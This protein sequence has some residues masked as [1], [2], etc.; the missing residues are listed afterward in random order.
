MNVADII[1]DFFA[2][3]KVKSLFFV[4][5]GGAMFLNDAISRQKKIIPYPNH[6]EQASTI[7]AE[8]Y[9]RVDENI[10]LAVV[11]TGPGGT[12][13]I[14]GIAGAWLESVPLFIITG[15]VKRSD[16]KKNSGVRQ[17]G[18][19]ELDIVKIVE[20][21]TKYSKTITNPNSILY[22]LE[23]AFNI[24]TTGR[25]GPVLL[26]IPLD[27]QASIVKKVD[28]ESFKNIKKIR[29][30]V[31][32]FKNIK[33]IING[34]SKPLILIGHGVRLSGG[35]GLIIKFIKKYKIPFVTT[36]NAMDIFPYDDKLNVGRPG[37]VALRAPNFAIQNCD[38]IIAIGA[39]LDNIVTAYNPA[40][41]AKNAKKIIVDI[42]KFELKKFKHKVDYKIN[43]SAN[44]FLTEFI[45]NIGVDF[46]N[47]SNDWK[48]QCIDWKQRYSINDGKAFKK[49]KEISHLYCV[50]ILSNILPENCLIVTGSSGLAIES[51]YTAFRN[52]KNQRIFLTSALGSMGYGIPALYGS[53]SSDK[54]KKIFCIESDGSFMMNMQ[55]MASLSNI[56]KDLKIIILNNK[57]YSSIRNTQRNYFNSRFLAVD[58][59]SNLNIPEFS[60][61]ADCFNFKHFKIDNPL[62][63][64]TQ[65]KKIIN[66]KGNIICE[67]I[68][69]QDD[70][71][72]PKSSAIPLPNG[73]IISMP[74]E[75]MSPLL[76]LDK[77]KLEMNNKIDPI[78]IKVRDKK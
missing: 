74:I 9:S 42:D 10:G 49:D 38:L 61:I 28:L 53:A 69:K 19:Q 7:S 21:I 5:G 78:S 58:K 64:D 71:L 77:L 52:K 3:K 55:E 40:N 12:N 11:T 56:Q 33:K 60:K 65:L 54:F 23:K 67:I 13:A 36:W 63:I 4:P 48:K 35:T 22:E 62:T 2:K 73:K 59:G 32:D 39:R 76:P 45:K 8:A 72:W 1:F 68:L 6:N 26:D 15:Q 27:I 30:N 43:V 37:N 17:K 47:S 57:G 46:F 41:F 44:I 14:T 70:A 16:L 51:F 34:T 66:L 24:A 25:K 75:D 29:S 50:D 31:I 18:P 20:S